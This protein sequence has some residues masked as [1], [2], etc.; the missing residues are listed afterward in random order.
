M[1]TYAAARVIVAAAVL[2]LAPAS[3]APAQAP[4]GPPQGPHIEY[5]EIIAAG[6]SGAGRP[7]AQGPIRRNV[8][9]TEVREVAVG[10]KFDMKIRTTG[11]PA[12][13]DIVLRFVW[14]APRPGIKDAKTGKFERE[15][16]VDVP[17]KIGA[18][19]ERTFEFK[20]QDQ[21]VKG[22]W[23][24]EVW[25]GRRRLVMRRFAVK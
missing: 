13:A 18:E 12:G 15:I 7:I 10:T 14:R 23:R 19:V 1:R 11:E 3:P 2:L 21:V 17:A 9:H 16:A 22:T 20:E 8:T 6:Y 4:H 25:N 24:A 5:A